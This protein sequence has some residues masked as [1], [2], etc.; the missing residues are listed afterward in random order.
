[1]KRLIKKIPQVVLTTSFTV[2]GLLTLSACT[3][4][5][6]PSTEKIDYGA[7]KK[8]RLLDIPPELTRAQT[9]P[10]SGDKGAVSYVDTEKE[11]A[12][13][14]NSGVDFDVAVAT[15]A[16]I[17]DMGVYRY[18]E[19][20]SDIKE[21][22][23]KLPEFLNS[24]GLAI[25]ENNPELGVINTTWEENKAKLPTSIFREKFGGIFSGLVNSGQMDRFHLLVEKRNNKTR[26][27]LSHYGLADSVRPNAK[28]SYYWAYRAPEPLLEMEMLK[29]L[30]VF[31][32]VNKPEE[33]TNVKN[34]KNYAEN[35]GDEI[36]I[37]DQ[38]QVAWD[39]LLA[40]IPYN[41]FNRSFVNYENKTINVT[42]QVPI[43]DAPNVP[44]AEKYPMYQITLSEQNGKTLASFKYIGKSV[45]AH[46]SYFSEAINK[47]TLALN[48]L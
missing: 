40:A 18:L 24:L 10:S 17:H 11:R 8:A 12:R 41:G 29:R 31:L 7:T 15:K 30:A 48:Q 39:K 33:K 37:N 36:L 16:V 26:V 44:S 3:I 25:L 6:G 42:T 45:D 14:V 22:W 9:A 19:T 23:R 21:L 34:S 13:A 43:K 1:M 4:T 5:G 2:F 32:G 35:R 20:D 28:D 38:W 47:L 27:Y 46:K